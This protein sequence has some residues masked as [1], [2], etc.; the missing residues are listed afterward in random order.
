[1]KGKATKRSSGKVEPA[2][3][4]RIVVD[5]RFGLD[6]MRLLIATLTGSV[7]EVTDGRSQWSAEKEVMVSPG[8]VSRKLVPTGEDRERRILQEI[9]RAAWESKAE[10]LKAEKRG[11]IKMLVWKELKEG[12]VF[13][14]GTFKIV[15]ERHDPEVIKAGVGVRDFLQVDRIAIFE[16]QSKTLYSGAL[17]GKEVSHA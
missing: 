11:S 4:R 14:E 5:E 8:N 13:L 3:V 17:L 10:E 6:R 1:M 16:E 12:Q 2:A 7:Q 15:G 9:M